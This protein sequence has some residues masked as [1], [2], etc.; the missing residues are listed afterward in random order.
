MTGEPVDV[1]G[2]SLDGPTLLR[3]VRRVGSVEV[4]PPPVPETDQQRKQ[5]D[6]KTTSEPPA[7]NHR[8]PR[9]PSSRIPALRRARR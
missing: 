1:N 8:C 7:A 2:Q 4:E 3:E 5:R 9:R 6:R